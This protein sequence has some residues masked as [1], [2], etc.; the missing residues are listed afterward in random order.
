MRKLSNPVREVDAPRIRA[1]FDDL[2]DTSLKW[3]TPAQLYAAMPRRP[4]RKGIGF[5]G[6][7]A[8][9]M[10]AGLPMLKTI[11]S[12]IE[13]SFSLPEE[14]RQERLRK[15]SR[16]ALELQDGVCD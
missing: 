8:G 16:Q 14:G 12:N 3:P 13:K 7:N 2:V 6:V 15:L 10:D 5:S 9:G 1:A 4:E 11:L